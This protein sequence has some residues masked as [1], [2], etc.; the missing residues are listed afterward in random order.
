MGVRG[1]GQLSSYG[2]N[3]TGEPFQGPPVFVGHHL[4]RHHPAPAHRKHVPFGKKGR[5]VVCVDSS[6][7][8]KVHVR[9]HGSEILEALHAH[10]SHRR[11]ELERGAACFAGGKDFGS[12]FGS[13]KVG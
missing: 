2:D 12:G 3:V 8:N 9:E 11:K 5:K 13:G 6:G 7:W 10:G 1:L 4:L